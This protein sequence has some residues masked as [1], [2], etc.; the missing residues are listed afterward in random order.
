MLGAA[1]VVGV[2]SLSVAFAL[3]KMGPYS[4]VLP[5]P[6]VALMKTAAL[7]LT[8]RPKVGRPRLGRMKNVL[9]R[10]SHL[11]GT[12][13]VTAAISQ[14]DYFVL[15]LFASKVE[16]GAYYFAF[17]LAVQPLQLLASSVTNVVFPVL[18]QMGNDRARQRAAALAAS[19]VLAYVAM[20]CCFLQAALA[21]PVLQLLA[22][23][24]WDAAVPIAQL[25][26]V[27]LAF[28]AVAWIAGAVLRARGE[29]FTTF[30]YVALS[31]V[32]FFTLV[33]TSAACG[34][35]KAMAVAL[36]VAIYYTAITPFY[37]VFA[38]RKLGSSV[39]EVMDVYLRPALLAGLSVAAGAAA[40]VP[41]S[42][43]PVERIAVT[44]AISGVGYLVILRLFANEVLSTIRQFVRSAI[45]RRLATAGPRT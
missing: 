18:A 28:D 34:S 37:S 21:A 42:A 11:L 38:F 29:F 12:K 6:I 25:L 7:W 35:N 5:L 9:A 26:S 15:G 24:K 30:A 14:G 4:F 32:A 44:L 22:G 16:V 10:G 36:A 39:A 1:E 31:A 23:H 33:V 20:P 8:T 17:R 43:H 2:Q 45:A 27:G 3:A 40:G 41:V 19:R 13:V